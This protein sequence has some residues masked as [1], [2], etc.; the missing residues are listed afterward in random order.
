VEKTHLVEGMATLGHDMRFLSGQTKAEGEGF[1]ADGA[2]LLILGRVVTGHDGERGMCH[3][4]EG[5]GESGGGAV[6]VG[7]RGRDKGAGR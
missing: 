6:R 3:E 5:M 2:V 1:E 4:S 7:E